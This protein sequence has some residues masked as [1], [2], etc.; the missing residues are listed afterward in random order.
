MRVAALILTAVLAGLGGGLAEI[1]ER[2]DEA[3]EVSLLRA[4][5]AFRKRDFTTARVIAGRLLLA[6][7]DLPG[8]LK[9][10]CMS[11]R[12][13]GESEVMT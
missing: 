8:F 3:T 12:R 1:P 11:G 2:D 13:I 6:E 5:L 9:A 10:L 7:T 4:E